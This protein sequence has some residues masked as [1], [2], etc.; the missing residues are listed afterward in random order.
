LTLENVL[1]AVEFDGKQAMADVGLE[2][3]NNFGDASI[4]NALSMT[5]K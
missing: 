4:Q 3:S 2:R 1:S 5:T